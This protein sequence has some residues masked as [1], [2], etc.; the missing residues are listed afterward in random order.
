MNLTTPLLKLLASEIYH[1]FHK[2][3][4]PPADEIYVPIDII[5]PDTEKANT[6]FATVRFIVDYAGRK[7]HNIRIKFNVDEKG[8]FITNS[9]I[10]V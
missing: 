9:W 6:Y 4:K 8:R 5:R 3:D 2:Q 7:V 10:Y 1:Y